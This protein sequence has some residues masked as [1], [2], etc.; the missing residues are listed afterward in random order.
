M[1]CK[2]FGILADSLAV[3]A[4]IFTFRAILLPTMMRFVLSKAFF[5][6]SNVIFLSP[7]KR[8]CLN[9]GIIAT[10]EVLVA[11]VFSKIGSLIDYLRNDF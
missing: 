8:I 3:G 5:G 1:N 7:K 11:L 4:G 6:H 9:D 10:R 2:H